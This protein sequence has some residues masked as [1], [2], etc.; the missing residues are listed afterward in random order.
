MFG[1]LAISIIEEGNSMLETLKN[2][3]VNA[4]LKIFA[5]DS[6]SRKRLSDPE[7]IIRGA[8]VRSGQ[9]V[10]EVG[11]GRGFFTLPL[12]ETV[13]QGGYLY[14]LDVTQAAVDYVIRKVEAANLS[15]TRAFK[16]NALDSGMPG[17]AVDL[18]L[19]FGVIPS[20]TLPLSRL[21]PEMHRVLNSSG[22]L[23]VWTAVPGWSP[24]TIVQSG[25]FD[26]IGKINNV[27]NFRRV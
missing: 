1:I 13:G 27:H 15:N 24:Q 7:L 6:P 9:K 11:C 10:L 22:S 18:V 8:G 5:S 16:A 21:L 25:L 23:A 4:L 20:P 2:K 26:Y 12:A 3:T 19:L 14:A 17:G